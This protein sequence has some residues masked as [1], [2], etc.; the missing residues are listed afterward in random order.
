MKEDVKKYISK[1]KNEIPLILD[2]YEDLFSDFDPRSYSKRAISKDFLNECK[3]ASKDKKG[4]IE[5]KLFLPKNKRKISAEAEIKKRLE[6][7]F[8]KH[9][10][11]KKKEL[12]F[13][14]T[15]G[16]IWFSVGCFLT[17]MTAL[18]MQKEVSFLVNVAINLAHP[19]G[20]F[21]LWEGLAK[22]LIHSKEKQEDY[23]FNKKM[24]EAKISFFN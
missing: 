3:N 7:H 24:K 5:I 12:I 13:L 22:I 19:A 9:F 21:F 16:G 6:E 11:S 14:K 17:A 23:D 2:G 4:K 20:W 18:F 1:D 15:T 10:L 8:Y